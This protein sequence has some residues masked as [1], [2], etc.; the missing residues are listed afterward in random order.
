MK[1]ARTVWSTGKSRSPNWSKSQTPE[2]GVRPTVPRELELGKAKG[3][4]DQ[5]KA[6]VEAA[7][8]DV[9]GNR[10]DTTRADQW[11]RKIADAIEEWSK[12]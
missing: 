6:L 3:R 1:P 9:L 11:R 4:V 5:A 12:P 10:S 2:P 8:A 7:V